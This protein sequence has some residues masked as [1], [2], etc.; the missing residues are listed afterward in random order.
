MIYKNTSMLHSLPLPTPEAAY[1]KRKTCTS[2]LNNNR[3][4]T[5]NKIPNEISTIK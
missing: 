4:K 3:T 2:Q 1:R 5:H